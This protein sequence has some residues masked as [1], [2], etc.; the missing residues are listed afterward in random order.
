MLLQPT[1]STAKVI[2]DLKPE[3][4][5]MLKTFPSHIW[6]FFIDL[7]CTLLYGSSNII[8]FLISGIPPP[9]CSG[10]NWVDCNLRTSRQTDQSHYNIS[11]FPENFI[12]LYWNKCKT[13]L[14]RKKLF[15]KFELL[16]SM[17]TILAGI[18]ARFS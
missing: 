7:F 13:P 5:N 6:R 4:K 16:L 17:D 12:Y 3:H 10:I 8:V 14:L 2:Y 1:L 15:G 9:K 11:T 18:K